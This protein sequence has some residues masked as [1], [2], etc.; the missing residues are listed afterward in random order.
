M[1][2]ILFGKWCQNL[3]TCLLLGSETTGDKRNASYSLDVIFL[4]G[5]REQLLCCCEHNT[6]GLW[7]D[8]YMVWKCGTCRNSS[9][10]W[11]CNKIACCGYPEP[12]YYLLLHLH[13]LRVISKCLLS[14]SYYR[15]HLSSLSGL[16][17]GVFNFSSLP[18]LELRQYSFLKSFD[19]S[20]IS[21]L[22]L[23]FTIHIILLY[24]T[25]STNWQLPRILMTN[26]NRDQMIPMALCY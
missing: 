19:D 9:P 4:C 22:A 12:T 20:S 17:L 6:G 14:F 2:C 25:F 10:L 26:K 8:D 13:I 15:K 24:F 3:F 5:W 23:M 7:L 16:N 11:Q 21:L 1:S 18:P